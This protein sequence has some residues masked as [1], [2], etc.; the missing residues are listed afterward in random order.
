MPIQ[1]HFDEEL[2]KLKQRIL[3]MGGLVEEQLQESLKALVERD[4]PLA[5]QVI[6]NDRRVNTLDVEVD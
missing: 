6:E 5:K 2:S 1:R 3:R 4:E